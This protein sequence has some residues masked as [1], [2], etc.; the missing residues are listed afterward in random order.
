MHMH[1][2]HPTNILLC[3]KD[4]CKIPRKVVLLMFSFFGKKEVRVVARTEGQSAC[5]MAYF[6]G[7]SNSAKCWALEC[8]I[9]PEKSF[10]PQSSSE[11]FHFLQLGS[12]GCLGRQNTDCFG[13]PKSGCS[14][15]SIFKYSTLSYSV[16]EILLSYLAKHSR[17]SCADFDDIIWWAPEGRRN[18]KPSYGVCLV[19]FWHHW[20]V[21]E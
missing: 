5:A 12:P 3:R 10:H 21:G 11:A 14:K 17:Q 6:W 13:Q 2:S 7:C 4:L 15:K 19:I 9:N 8:Q 16:G 1:D 20:K 18:H